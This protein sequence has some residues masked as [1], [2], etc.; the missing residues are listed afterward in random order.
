[1][2]FLFDYTVGLGIV[3][4][5]LLLLALGRHEIEPLGT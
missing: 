2:N 4:F 5:H 3:V 1:M